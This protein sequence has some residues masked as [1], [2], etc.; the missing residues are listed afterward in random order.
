MMQIRLAALAVAT[1]ALSG[2]LT[3][4]PCGARFLRERLV[5][6]HWHEHESGGKS[7]D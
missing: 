3:S 7:D 6:E 5:R 4:L 1:V 2:C